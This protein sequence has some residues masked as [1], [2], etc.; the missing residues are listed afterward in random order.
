MKRS[1]QPSR[2]ARI[3]GADNDEI[4]FVC[5]SWTH[6]QIEYS[7]VICKRTGI[8]SC[9]CMDCSCRKKQADLLALLH[10]AEAG[11][12]HI[13]GMVVAYKS[14]LQQIEG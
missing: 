11:C 3:V 7:I 8:V 4:Q 12:K 6:P 13:R 9:D 1:T 10:G 14:L 5:P 2:L